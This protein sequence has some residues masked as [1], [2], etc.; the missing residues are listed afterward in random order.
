MKNLESKTPVLNDLIRLTNNRIAGYEQAIKHVDG[1]THLQSVFHNQIVQSYGFITAL[2]EAIENTGGHVDM[3]QSTIEGKIFRS[4][5]EMK[6]FF[7]KDD[8]KAILES[9]VEGE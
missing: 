3:D 2:E 7:A 5:M 1:A 8:R 4:W 9:C 6:T